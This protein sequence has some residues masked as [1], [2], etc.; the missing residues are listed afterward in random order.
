MKVSVSVMGRFHA[1]DLASQLEKRGHLHQL[2]TSYPKFEVK[3]RGIPRRRTTSILSSELLQRGWHRMPASLKRRGDPGDR[4]HRHYD[5]RATR[6]LH[7][8]ADLFVGW[9]GSSLN[10]IRRARALGMV[11]V[12][13]RGSSHIAFQRD[14]LREEYEREGLRAQLPHPAIVETELAEYNEADYIAIPSDFVKRTFVE[15]GVPE[16]KLLHL[17]YGVSLES[18]SPARKQ[19]DVF[20]IIHCGAVNLR[21]GC[22]YLLQAF[23]ELD[24]PDAELWFV[25]PVAAETE[26]FRARYAS[27]SIVYHGAR[28]QAELARYYSQSSVFCLASIEEGLAMVIPQAMACGLPVL[29]TDHTGAADVVRNGIDGYIVGIRDVSAL[30]EKILEMYENRERCET[31]GESARK[32]VSSGF[33]WDDYGGRV[34]AA[35]SRALSERI[36]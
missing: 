35:Y 13:E 31:M 23:S 27:S 7:G 9:S 30:K 5:L 11:T 14:I 8:G 12:V 10:A 32:R 25:G 15:L 3:K 19:D 17:P 21:K 28:P 26:S 16:S 6:A 20:R 2:I 1:F 24:L 33:T 34:A 4:F 18:F 22:H 29:A 36:A